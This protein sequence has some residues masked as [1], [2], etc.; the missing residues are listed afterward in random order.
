MN[1]LISRRRLVVRS[2]ALLATTALARP[3]RAEAPAPAREPPEWGDLLRDLDRLQEAMWREILHIVND[4]V[5]TTGELDE[6][7]IYGPGLR[8]AG[9]GMNLI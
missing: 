8:W 2:L 4:G 1:T 5:A 9:M 3:A 7:I 6:S